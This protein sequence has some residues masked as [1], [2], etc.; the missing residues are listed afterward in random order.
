MQSPS[1]HLC[2]LVAVFV[3]AV[4][5]TP[6]PGAAGR[7]PDVKVAVHAVY[8]EA[9][10]C[11]ENFP[12]ITGCEDITPMG[13]GTSHDPDVFPVFYDIVEYR[14][15]EYA[16]TFP[17]GL[18]ITFHSCSDDAVVEGSSDYWMITHTYDTC[19]PGPVAMPGWFVL[20][21]EAGPACMV[22]HPSTRTIN[23]GDCQT[24]M[25][26]DHPQCGYCGSTGHP[27]RACDPCAPCEPSSIERTMWGGVK[28]LFR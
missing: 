3:A 25:Q 15:L 11:T 18:S 1:I 19:R 24:P 4:A 9:R 14:L 21:Y 20:V 10:T 12:I 16:M 23:I 27:P 5:V 6:R 8:Q 7:N 28:S 17:L 2:L 22:S 13:G 26:V